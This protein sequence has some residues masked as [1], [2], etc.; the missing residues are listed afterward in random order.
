MNLKILEL[1][2]H[3]LFDLKQDGIYSGNFYYPTLNR[4]GWYLLGNNCWYEIN[5]IAYMSDK[6]TFI[7]RLDILNTRAY[8]KEEYRMVSSVL[9]RGLMKDY[10]SRLR[11]S[12]Y[13]DKTRSHKEELFKIMKGLNKSYSKKWSKL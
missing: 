5:G 13:M 7:N 3:F 10:A 4:D 12:W 1:P 11:C 8:T 9:R 6:N 2:K